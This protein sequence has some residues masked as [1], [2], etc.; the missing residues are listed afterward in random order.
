MRKATWKWKDK[1]KEHTC[2]R[3]TTVVDTMF[4]G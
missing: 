3:S 1:L 2:D 4:E